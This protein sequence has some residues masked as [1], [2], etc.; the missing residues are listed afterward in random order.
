MLDEAELLLA[1]GPWQH[2]DVS[3]N[4]VRF[5]IVE[6]GE[7]PLILLLHGF[8]QFWWTWRHQIPALADGGFR[9]AVPDLRG[10][11]ASDKPARGYD[12]YTSAAD[13]AGLVRALGEREATVVGHDWGG[14]L[15]W[16]AATMHP[17][18]VTSLVILSVAHPMRHREAL[19]KDPRGQLRASSYMMSAQ[20]PWLAERNLVRDDAAMVSRLLDEW[21]GPGFPDDDARARYRQA[22]QVR[23]VS[24]TALEYYRWLI[25]AQT[26][27]S[28]I[29]YFKQMQK[30]VT[31]PTLQLHGSLD[32]CVL[33]RTAL[34]SGRYVSGTYEW[35]LI[36]GVGHFLPEEAPEL[37]TSEILRW[38]KGP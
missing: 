31:A 36:D 14:L 35:R 25:R 33:P 10:Y 30:P 12:L 19:V 38:A 2:R 1:A 8:P 5:H 4:G 22:I 23:H 11:G 21:G 32:E 27:R 28:G 13:V 18:V 20:L 7:G 26:R 6:A 24:N 3:A 15:A 17:H 29:R 37:V 16:T 34:G 9:I